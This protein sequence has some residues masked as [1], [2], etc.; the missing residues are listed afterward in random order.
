MELLLDTPRGPLVR[1]YSLCGEPSDQTW[2]RIGVLRAPDGRGASAYLH[3]H[4]HENA[5]LRA[6]RPHNHF[7]LRSAERYLFVAGGV[8]IT[9]IVPMVREVASS[10]VEWQ[11]MYTARSR[12]RMAFADELES[13]GGERVSLYESAER[14]RLDATAL[15]AHLDPGTAV[16]ACGPEGLLAELERAPAGGCSLHLERF[17]TSAADP[18][19]DTAF[20][21]VLQRTGDAYRVEPGRSVLEV[22]EEAGVDIDCSCGEGTCGTCE[23]PVL[24]GEIDH[25]DAVLTPDERAAGDYMMVCVS[26]S[27]SP[28]L[29]L[30]A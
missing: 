16:Y 12:S 30:D 17:A 22:L 20:E 27:L 24:E 13:L 1:Q 19:K 2:W 29:V 28:R 11:L 7:P 21:V 25:R 18:A 8:G 5:A 14:G 6:R 9:P 10:G 4:V 3:D 23:T 15:T 26:R